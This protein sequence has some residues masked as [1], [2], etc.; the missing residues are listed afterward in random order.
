MKNL[1]YLFLIGVLF[2]CG[3]SG[4]D[5]LNPEEPDV[6]GEPKE[7]IVS[8]GMT[9]EIEVSESPLLGRASSDDLY[10]VQVYSK[11]DKTSS[12]YA[13]GLFD[14][15]SKMIIKLLEGYK[16]TF[17]VTMIID[18]KNKIYKNKSGE[19]SLPFATNN[20]GTMLENTFIYESSKS[21]N[22]LNWGFSNLVDDN[23]SIQNFK[24]PNTDRYYGKI[25]DYTPTDNGN[26]SID[27]K[28]VS[29]G[30]KFVSEGLT[31]GKLTISIQN[32]PE[33]NIIYGETTEA[34]D[35]FTFE[36]AVSSSIQ[37]YWTDDDYSETIPV[38][39]SWEKSDGAIIPIVTGQ[40]ITFKRKTLTT[41]TIKVKDTSVN[42]GVEI[43][44]EPGN[45]I[46]GDNITLESGTGVDS[47]V[48]PNV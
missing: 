15:K 25:T 41:I 43:N 17:E 31:E 9:G 46:D 23:S 28:R 34:Q 22:K 36:N 10:G 32:A 19:Y 7:Y 4:E 26:V 35:I 1:L 33:L 2:S 20:E 24:I 48:E 47:P 8:L 29:F 5:E 37:G 30:A 12:A 39:V 38:S 3:G 45:L 27:M 18:G 11:T 44:Q 21:M 13:Y 14:D 16:Y 6:N 42:N 40:L